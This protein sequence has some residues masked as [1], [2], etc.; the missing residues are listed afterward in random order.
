MRQRCKL[1][2]RAIQAKKKRWAILAL[3][4]PRDGT[5]GFVV[6]GVTGCGNRISGIILINA[7]PRFS[8]L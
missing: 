6:H 4:G 1:N 5:V 3:R 7:D 8:D 2:P